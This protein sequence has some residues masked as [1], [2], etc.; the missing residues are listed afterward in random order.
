MYKD[1]DKQREANRLA[2]ARQRAKQGM[3]EQGMTVTG[4]DD[5]PCWADG[6]RVPQIEYDFSKK[7]VRFKLTSVPGAVTVPST[8]Q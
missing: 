2:K 5:E 7:R 6:A 3:T 8:E 1:K 4:S